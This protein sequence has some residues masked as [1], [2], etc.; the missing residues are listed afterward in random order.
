[1]PARRG[2][3][4][5]WVYG[6]RCSVYLFFA[7]LI[8]VAGLVTTPAATAD[9]IGSLEELVARARAA[10]LHR[11]RPWQVLLHYTPT[12]SDSPHSLVDD[13]KFFL[14]ADGKT[15]PAAELEATLRGFFQETSAGDDAVRCRFPARFSWLSERL[16]IAAERLPPVTCRQLEQAMA[17]TDPQRTVLVFPAAYLNNPASMFGHTFL[18][19]DSGYQ[20]P[21]LGYAVNY[22][23]YPPSA[24]EFLHSFKGIFGYFPGYYSIL[25]YYEK[26]KEYTDLEHRDIWEYP[27]TLTP[28]ETRQLALHTWELQGIY[29]DYYF[30]D[31]NCSFNILFLEEAARPTVNLTGRLPPWVI[32]IDTIRASR[33]AGLVAGAI[34]RP[35]QATRIRH[36]ASLLPA[37]AQETAVAIAR[38]NAP[39]ESV[40]IG[41]LPVPI[42]GRSLELASEL[43]QYRYAR[44]ELAKD[45]YNRQFLAI[46][47]VRSSL[48]PAA[49]AAPDIPAPPRPDQGHASNRLALAVGVWQ[50]RFFTELSWRPAY[51]NLLDPDAGYTAG[52]QID[53]LD[54]SIRYYPEEEELKLQRLRFIDI[55]SLAPRDIMFKPVS[56]AVS[57]G[58]EQMVFA[59]G[60]QHLAGRL[61]SGAGLAYSLGWLGLAYVLAE[62][63]LNLSDQLRDKVAIGFGGTAGIVRE[64][65]DTWKVALTF[66]GFSYPFFEVHSRLQATLAQNFR[67]TANQS[68]ELSLMAER[69]FEY[70]RTEARLAWKFYF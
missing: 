21:L 66:Q 52:A 11:E 51:H 61:T 32:P 17:A 28:A 34:Y 7:L 39:P 4:Q 46:L 62:A 40:R 42:Q 6:A 65:A 36:L 29:S 47:Q 23:A 41:S 53:F 1:M 3:P 64:F 63:D 37:Q 55:L 50:G 18:R 20:S 26:V 14:A 33:D 57:A 70:D 49:G 69:T 60:D 54:L 43:L 16:G 25:P 48:G 56:W 5:S 10:Q 19:V 9:E 12:D 2:T 59:D 31:E 58:L 44:K 68:I 67:I 15:N 24:D 22:S 30:F 35:S 8:A 27:L 13:P 45:E 38:G